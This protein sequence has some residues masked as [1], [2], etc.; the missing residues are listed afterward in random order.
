MISK[1]TIKEETAIVWVPFDTNIY[2]L[3]TLPSFDFG[4][5]LLEPYEAPANLDEYLRKKTQGPR[6]DL[7]FQF[8]GWDDKAIKRVVEQVKILQ[9]LDKEEFKS[10]SDSWILQ[11]EATLPYVLASLDC[12]PA[13]KESYA[14]QTNQ[15][16]LRKVFPKKY[17]GFG[18]N[19]IGKDFIVEIVINKGHYVWTN[20]QFKGIESC[21]Y[22]WLK[23][24]SEIDN[25]KNS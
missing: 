11:T 19:L 10:F 1:V 2:G 18:I 24:C 14:I 20:Y 4:R 13:Q 9:R 17:W 12:D 25:A 21:N 6:E 5:V 22:M 15:G 16:Y 8:H 23:L 3:K 7:G